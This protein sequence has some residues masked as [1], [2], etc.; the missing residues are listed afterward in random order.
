MNR[1]KGFTL[2][3][4]LLVIAIIT[5]LIAILVPVLPR[6]I[7]A[8]NMKKTQIL[9]AQLG[10]GLENYK[11]VYKDYPLSSSMGSDSMNEGPTRLLTALQG[12]DGQ[13]WTQ[14]KDGVKTE[15]GPF[16]E[17][18]KDRLSRDGTYFVDGF[19][20][21]IIYHKAR[22]YKLRPINNSNSRQMRYYPREAEKWWTGSYNQTEDGTRLSNT[23]TMWYGYHWR[24]KLTRTTRIKNGIT[25]MLPHNPT[26]YVLWS[27]GE[28]RILGY[29]NTDPESGKMTFDLENGKCDDITNF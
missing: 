27:A 17:S 21:V 11:R 5:V 15:F 6:V 24:K 16:F 25:E 13:G 26:T 20:N 2:I 12:P 3:E 19:G 9:F 23:G 1:Q 10:V 4:M 28:D 7:S 22:M 18:V 8:T 29:T 14:A